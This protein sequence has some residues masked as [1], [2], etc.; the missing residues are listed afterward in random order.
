MMIRM[1]VGA[2]RMLKRTP[3]VAPR[4]ERELPARIV[5][6]PRPPKAEASAPLPRVKGRFVSTKGE[7]R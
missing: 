4:A 3:T 5:E 1:R 7:K 6:P 2:E